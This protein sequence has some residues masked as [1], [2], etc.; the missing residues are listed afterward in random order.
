MSTERDPDV[1]A[2]TILIGTVFAAFALVLLGVPWPIAVA[3]GVGGFFVSRIIGRRAAAALAVR[4]N[5]QDLAG[6][7]TDETKDDE[8]P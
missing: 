7:E 1:V 8:Q 6:P 5:P 3:A 2:R 4:D